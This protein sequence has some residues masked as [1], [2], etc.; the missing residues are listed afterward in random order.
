MAGGILSG[1]TTALVGAS[2]VGK[3][4]LAFQFIAEGVRQ[5]EPGIFCSL[6]ESPEQL[7]RMAANYGYDAGELQKKWHDSGFNR[8]RRK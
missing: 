2:G 3:T 7:S 1:S 5:G 4:T 6:E 8:S